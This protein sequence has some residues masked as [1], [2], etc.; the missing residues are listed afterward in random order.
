M[1][2]EVITKMMLFRLEDFY[3]LSHRRFEASVKDI[4]LLSLFPIRISYNFV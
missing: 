4:G 1:L 3:D 2:Y